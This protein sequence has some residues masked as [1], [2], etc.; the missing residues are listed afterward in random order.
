MNS[1]AR[2]ARSSSKNNKKESNGIGGEP[3]WRTKAEVSGE[4][5][6]GGSELDAI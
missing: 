2:N 1:V 6:T 3:L 4:D 5:V